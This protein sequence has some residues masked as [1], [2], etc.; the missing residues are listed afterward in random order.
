MSS[1]S[2]GSVMSSMSRGGVMTHRSAGNP[3]RTVGAAVLLAAAALAVGA[4][5]RMLAE[6]EVR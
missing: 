6:P 4:A 2:V 5:V 3:T 1:M